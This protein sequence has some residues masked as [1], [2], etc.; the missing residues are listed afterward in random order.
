MGLSITFT[1][2]LPTHAKT[3]NIVWL[4]HYFDTNV[5]NSTNTIVHFDFKDD[6]KYLLLSAWSHTIHAAQV[7][8][9]FI[10]PAKFEQTITH[11]RRESLID[12][13]AIPIILRLHVLIAD[14]I[15]NKKSLKIPKG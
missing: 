6:N 5:S 11:H 14:R 4:P 9:S 13:T 3:H 1:N 10:Q 8:C 7:G 2:I 15:F 12:R